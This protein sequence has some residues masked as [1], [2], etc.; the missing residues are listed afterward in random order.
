MEVYEKVAKNPKYLRNPGVKKSRQIRKI[1]MML[2][3]I[4]EKV[5]LSNFCLGVTGEGLQNLVC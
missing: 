5:V 3:K 4:V 2:Q 1:I